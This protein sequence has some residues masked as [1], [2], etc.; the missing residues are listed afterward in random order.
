VLQAPVT[1]R[2]LCTSRE[3]RL[4]ADACKAQARREV[5]RAT[6]AAREQ[7]GEPVEDDPFENE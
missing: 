7:A 3:L 5:E 6:A 2:R 1:S 4:F